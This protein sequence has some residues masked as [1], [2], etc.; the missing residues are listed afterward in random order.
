MIRE[1]IIKKRFA[2]KVGAV[3]REPTILS[4][5]DSGVASQ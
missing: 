4:S 3:D 2:Q 1:V 5:I